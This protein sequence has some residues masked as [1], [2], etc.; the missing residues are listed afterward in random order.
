MEQVKAMG[1]YA[2][3]IS[4]L[5]PFNEVPQGPL[6]KYWDGTF[7]D[8]VKWIWYVVCWPLIWLYAYKK[9]PEKFFPALCIAAVC[10]SL[11]MIRTRIREGKWAVGGGGK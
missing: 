4:E 7:W 10:F 1:L 3:G 6:G 8:A 9:N 11:F 5:T 2:T